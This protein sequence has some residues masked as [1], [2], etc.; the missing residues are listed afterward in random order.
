[1]KKILI[2]ILFLLIA[3]TTNN[4]IK[5]YEPIKGA[6][7]KKYNIDVKSIEV[8]NDQIMESGDEH[9]Y[10]LMP[11]MPD[12]LL[13]NWIHDK[14]KPVGIRRILRV[15]IDASG[16]SE[17]KV[18][19]KTKGMK[20][21]FSPKYEDLY[22]GKY[23]VKFEIIDKDPFFPTAEMTVTVTSSATASINATIAEKEALFY[24]LVKDLISNF[25]QKFD[26][27]VDKYLHQYIVQR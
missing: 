19:T 25:N 5:N 16:V 20:A 9:L 24:D 15:V 13:E 11:Y 12:E 1:M 2:G 10:R 6:K 4:E 21:Y 27:N 7:G 22:E 26:K 18:K 14:L 8:V 17:R 3:C 23:S